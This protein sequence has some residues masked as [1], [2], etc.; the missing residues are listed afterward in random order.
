MGYETGEI[1]IKGT[2]GLNID[3][4]IFHVE[5]SS[6]MVI[7]HTAKNELQGIQLSPGEARNLANSLID[8][9]AYYGEEI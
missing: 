5:A 4:H 7:I 6:G 3:S 9:A 2:I 1:K 8:A